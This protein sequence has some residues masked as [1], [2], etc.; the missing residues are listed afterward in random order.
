MYH[1]KIVS[2]ESQTVSNSTLN[3]IKIVVGS[4]YRVHINY[5]TTKKARANNERDVEVLGFS[6]D[7]MGDVIIRY[8]DTGR[9]GRISPC[10]L[11]S[12]DERVLKDM[13]NDSVV[14]RKINVETIMNILKKEK[15]SMALPLFT[16]WSNLNDFGYSYT[17][18]IMTQPTFYR[19]IKILKSLG[20]D[21]ANDKSIK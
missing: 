3:N 21:W 19:H 12:T 7:F 6:D 8:K 10:W 14:A 13:M 9:R 20:I 11:I 18:S 4:Q 2:V 1:M 16:T 5:P 17:K 15:P